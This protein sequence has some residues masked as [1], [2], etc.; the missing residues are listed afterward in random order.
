MK[1]SVLAVLLNMPNVKSL[2]NSRM[3]IKLTVYFG[4]NL[5]DYSN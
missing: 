4:F 2:E 5:F 3:G 1:C